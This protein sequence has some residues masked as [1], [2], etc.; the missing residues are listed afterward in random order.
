MTRHPGRLAV[1]LMNLG[2]PDTLDS[3]RPFLRNL[4]SDPAIISLPWPL[5]TFVAEMISRTRNHK[6]RKVYQQIGGGSPLLS[7]T[8]DQSFHL[9]RSLHDQLPNQEVEVF[10]AMRYWHPLTA[11][12]IAHVK[13]FQPTEIVLLPL[14]PHF[15]TTTTGSSFSEWHQQAYQQGLTVPTREIRCYPQD[16]AFI[17]AHV[18]LLGPWI[19]KAALYG[20]PRI[21]FSAHGLPQRVID[22]GD[23]YEG[24]IHQT[25]QA[26]LKKISPSVESAVCYQSKVGPL[27]WLRP[28]TE[29]ELKRAGQDKAP[30]II[31]PVSFVSEHVETLVELDRDYRSLA[32]EAGV[33]FYGRVRTLSDHPAYIRAL[34]GL[35]VTS[36]NQRL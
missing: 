5:R 12:V 11:E 9:C 36:L 3:V 23:P 2:G 7:N 24:Q 25:T 35:V 29:E 20:S 16:P 28:S 1:V 19:E 21:L 4:F 34:A 17:E 30:V 26:I 33:P 10:I 13:A 6:A 22:A 32:E 15:S 31:V 27:K 8:K 18:D 14:Y